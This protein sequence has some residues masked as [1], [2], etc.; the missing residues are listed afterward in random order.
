MENYIN[1]DM[2]VSVERNA[3]LCGLLRFLKMVEAKE[4]V[5]YK[6]NDHGL[7]VSEEWL[8]NSNVGKIYQDSI[9]KIHK[10]ELGINR[11]IKKIDSLLKSDEK[12]INLD[13]GKIKNYIEIFSKSTS[14]E[15]K[16]KAQTLSALFNEAKKKKTKKDDPEEFSKKQR[17]HIENLLKEFEREDIRYRLEIYDAKLM[18]QPYLRGVSFLNSSCYR[19]S[20]IEEKYNID[21]CSKLKDS[22]NEKRDGENQCIDCKSKT[23]SDFNLG[24]VD[25]IT[26]A[27]KKKSYFYNYK[28]GAIVCP[29]CA[30]L[31]TF[32]P[33]GF[34]EIGRDCI[35]INDNS[36]FQNLIDANNM[37]KNKIEELDNVKEYLY[38][39]LTT[40]TLETISKRSGL[41][42][43]LRTNVD[44][45]W[46]KSSIHI[47]PDI[48][49]LFDHCKNNFENLYNKKYCIRNGSKVIWKNAY[50][51]TIIH[52][53]NRKPLFALFD[54]VFKTQID[55]KIGYLY[56]LLCIETYKIQKGEKRMG[57]L[58]KS[59]Y[60]A[61]K[62]GEDLRRAIYCMN[63]LKSEDA[64]QRK[65]NGMLYSMLNSIAANDRN[66]F[67]DKVLRLSMSANKS[68]PI[69][70]VNVL[71]E[72]DETFDVVGRAFL[73][74]LQSSRSFE[75]NAESE[76]NNN[77]EN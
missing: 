5:D 15:L 19:S 46:K 2:G 58:E 14:D 53:I 74:G 61:M 16:E 7:E 40:R 4:G 65:L 76:K 62:F 67:M 27:K 20:E 57:N 38:R 41:E 39:Y 52:I 66:A 18:F 60:A 73:L 21:F 13:E 48:I 69:L 50:D 9:I 49:D 44:K 43:A 26:D 42:I 77:E 12:Q 10:D 6:T 23:K 33:F 32:I 8:F 1:F 30:F 51:E 45:D 75:K 59:R 11:M 28:S 22:L 72:D 55:K 24:F 36:S 34:V 29:K 47:S 35:F 37:V 54:S 63:A 56:N 31:Y 3:G 71:N 70:F 64:L 68:V 17:E 25:L